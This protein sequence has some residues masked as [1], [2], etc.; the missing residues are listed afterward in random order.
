MTV[1]F[2]TV[3]DHTDAAG[4]AAPTIPAWRR[5]WPAL[6]AMVLVSFSA[7]TDA[8][9]DDLEPPVEAQGAEAR[10]HVA[11][12]EPLERV[13]RR[14][15]AG[16]NPQTLWAD[17]AD[18]SSRREGEDG[19]WREL[20]RLLLICAWAGALDEP[21][22][23]AELAARVRDEWPS[24]SPDRLA[25]DVLGPDR[26]DQ[27]IDAMEY[28]V[29]DDG[30]FKPPEIPGMGVLAVYRPNSGV[31]MISYQLAF[32]PQLVTTR[33]QGIGLLG[34]GTYTWIWLPVGSAEVEVA[35]GSNPEAQTRLDV[36]IEDGEVTW[37]KLTS[38][39]APTNRGETQGPGA[40]YRIPLFGGE[41]TPS[42]VARAARRWQPTP[43][44]WHQGGWR[45]P[46]AAVPRH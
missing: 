10:D 2:S 32:T 46:R 23:M 39:H 3:F 29:G 18:L 14:L 1:R 33:G 42:R 4:P 45:A 22:A 36:P 21:R 43:A 30:R 25:R 17:Y 13:L 9:A 19:A 11:I 28:R 38:L 12:E 20:D 40:H 8:R 34:E 37:L 5:A 16:E 27:V 6:V 7:T 31:A 44:F 15:S 41:E 26:A 24:L 35:F